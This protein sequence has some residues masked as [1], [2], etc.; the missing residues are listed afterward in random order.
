M[1]LKC[2]DNLNTVSQNMSDCLIN[3]TKNNNL[4]FDE[5]YFLANADLFFFFN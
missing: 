1:S 2:P 5:I 4:K 3:C